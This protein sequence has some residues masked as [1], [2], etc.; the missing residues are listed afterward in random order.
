MH[1]EEDNKSGERAR[2]NSPR[3]PAKDLILSSL[4]K[5]RLPDDLT[6][7]SHLDLFMH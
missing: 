3:G 2:R 6:A 4:E 1:S 7:R 5:R